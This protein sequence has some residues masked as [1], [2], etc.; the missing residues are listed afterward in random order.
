MTVLC[1]FLSDEKMCLPFAIAAGPRQRKSLSGPSPAELVPMF[2]CLR[3]ET[4]PT[5][6]ARSPYVYRPGTEWPS[7]TLR[8]WV[9][10]QSPPTA[11]RA[12]VEIF[13]PP[14]H[15]IC[16]IK[17]ELLYDWQFTA[18]QFVLASSPLRHTTRDFFN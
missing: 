12:T 8:H 11:R 3:S 13:I 6:R 14:P 10:F 4:L 7:Y 5:W 15:G 2:Y 1:N 18:N 16:V 17:S 9:P